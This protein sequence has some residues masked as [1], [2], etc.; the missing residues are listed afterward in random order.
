MDCVTIAKPD[1]TPVA[2]YEDFGLDATFGDKDNDFELSLPEG[3]RMGKGWMWWVEGAEYG[4]VV[5]RA[6]MRTAKGVRSAGYQGRT[7]TGVLASKILCPPQGSDYLTLSGDA[8][9]CVRAVLERAQAN[10]VAAPAT[11]LSG[12]AANHRFERYCDA[13]DGLRR[14]LRTAGARPDAAWRNGRAVIGAAPVSDF[15]RYVDDDLLDL[16][17]LRQWRCTNHL[18]CLGV[19]ELAA[20]TVVHLYADAAGNV[21][22]TQTLFG[23]DE[24][25][26]KYDYSNAEAAEL[27]EKGAEKLRE[28]QT[29]GSVGVTV[30]DDAVTLHLGDVVHGRDNALGVDVHGEVV[31]KTVKRQRGAWSVDYE[32][33]TPEFGGSLFESAET[34]NYR[35]HMAAL[36]KAQMGGS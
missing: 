26:E 28:M 33:G 4:G 9:D 6:T 5:D 1:G 14:M 12:I 2:E 35:E 16:D 30:K 13:W 22:K 24:I 36:A 17:I 25:T 11:V 18:V 15:G 27:E 23:A 7:W 3:V 34:P 8:T 32:I 29:E 20:R 10:D 31:Q 21:G 19:G